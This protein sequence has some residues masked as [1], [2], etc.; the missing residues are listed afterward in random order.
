MA[1]SRIVAI[2]AIAPLLPLILIFLVLSL[3]RVFGWYLQGQTKT[4]KDAIINRVK[5]EQP[6]I[7]ETQA[8]QE[9]DDGWEKI[10]KS[11]T[12]ENGKSFP[13]DWNGLVG[14]FHPFW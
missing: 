10:E 14:F 3:L 11:G 4:R 5:A 2:M 8:F 12:A 7:S 6:A 1:T 13:D 9:A